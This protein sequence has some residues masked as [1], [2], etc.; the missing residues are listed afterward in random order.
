MF[1]VNLWKWPNDNKCANWLS[2]KGNNQSSAFLD[3]HD[4]DKLRNFEY[5]LLKNDRRNGSS[6]GTNSF[7]KKY[8]L[9]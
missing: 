7:V 5:S 9:F 3:I 2:F 4:L 8:Q 6:N 1:A